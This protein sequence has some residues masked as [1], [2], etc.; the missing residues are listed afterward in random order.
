MRKHRYLLL[1]T[2]LLLCSLLGVSFVQAAEQTGQ[3]AS[4]GSEPA[5]GASASVSAVEFT[6]K[7]ADTCIKC[8][9]EDSEYPVFDIFKTK[10]GVQ[11]DARTPFGG[12]Q[13]EACHGPGESNPL[14]AE[15]GKPPRSHVAKIRT[16][17][18]RPPML[19]FGA[20]S[21]VPVADQNR[22][23][24][25]CH[26]GDSHIA[27][28]GSAHEAGEVACASCHT[29]H[30]PHDAVLDKET[31]PDK[32]FTCHLQQRAEFLKPSNHPVR[33][34]QVAC[35]DCHTTHGSATAT[36]LARPT[37][38]E[39][40]YT[41]HAEKRGPFLWEHAP[42][43]EDCSLCHTPHGSVHPALLTK[44][45]P[46]LCQQCHAQEYH[47]SDA[48]TAAGLPGGTGSPSAFLL[49]GSCTNCHSQVHGSNH[50][51][52]VKLMR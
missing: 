24:L 9:D 23:C 4:A 22:M 6:K 43:S 42:A 15:D 36:L 8:H 50:P 30:T 44:R 19:A 1:I 13:C 46:L 29:I 10:H 3:P 35:S 11:A 2:P 5:Q 20:K 25:T 26:A 39:T 38:N 34:G 47:P 45:P 37:L 7:G 31:Q 51:S 16:G 40:C 33:F 21:H 32:C 41:C 18:Q 49:A 52:G 17:E 14:F 48:Y 12:L 27:W 28:Q